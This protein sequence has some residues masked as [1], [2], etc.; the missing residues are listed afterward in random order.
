MPF[1]Y[2]YIYDIFIN[3]GYIV[4][5]GEGKIEKRLKDS[6]PYAKAIKLSTSYII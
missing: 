5:D 6:M 3:F 1:I 2:L 4:L